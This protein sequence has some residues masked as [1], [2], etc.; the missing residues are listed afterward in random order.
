ML[1]DIL[2]LLLLQYL[3]L[4]QPHL[5]LSRRPTKHGLLEGWSLTK[6]TVNTAFINERPVSR[7]M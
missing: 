7:H 5:Q 3:K 4:V 2:L 1:G 6:T